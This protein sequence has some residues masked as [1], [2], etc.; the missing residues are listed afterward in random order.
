MAVTIKLKPGLKWGD[1]EN[2]TAKDIAF[3]AHVARDPKSGFYLPKALG[4]CR[5]GRCRRR[6]HR[7]HPSR[8]ALQTNYNEWAQLLPEHIEGPVYDEVAA[9]RRL[10]QAERL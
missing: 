8:L 10:Q 5:E 1:G 7:R 3:T 2:V 6:P 9:T 4:A